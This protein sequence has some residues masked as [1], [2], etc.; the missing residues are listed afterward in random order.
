MPKVVKK[1]A[2]TTKA[3]KA[4]TSKAKADKVDVADALAGPAEAPAEVTPARTPRQQ[5]IPGTEPPS[6]PPLEN[7]AEHYRRLVAE[8]RKLKD[9]V[10]V[11][12]ADLLVQCEKAIEEG[13]ITL[14]PDSKGRKIAIYRYTDD[15]GEDREIN[16]KHDSKAGVTVAKSGAGDDDAEDAA[17]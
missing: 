17:A 2:R 4:K 9:A 10:Q 16:Y 12:A 14:P 7:A 6:I 11:A 13:K 3:S 1:P 5:Y 15:D 8:Q